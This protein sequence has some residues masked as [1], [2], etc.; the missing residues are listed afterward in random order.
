MMTHPEKNNNEINPFRAECIYKYG[1]EDGNKKFEYLLHGIRKTDKENSPIVVK[2]RYLE[3]V[4]LPYIKELKPKKQNIHNEFI[5]TKVKDNT[6]IG[7]TGL[8]QVCTRIFYSYDDQ[9][10]IFMPL[11]SICF[12]NKKVDLNNNYY[13]QLYDYYIGDKKVKI[14]FDVYC[15]NILGAYK[16]DESYVEGRYSTFNKPNNKLLCDGEGKKVQDIG[17]T[18]TV[19]RIL[20]YETDILGN[21][22]VKFDTKDII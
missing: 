4:N 7:L 9:K 22:Y 17:I 14:M 2:L 19:I 13:K 20:L 1:L 11:Y 15:G 3:K 10:F 16:K 12:K 21:K 5:E 18:T 8:G 6:L